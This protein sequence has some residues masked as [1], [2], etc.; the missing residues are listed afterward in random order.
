MTFLLAL[1]FASV[2]V[3][4]APVPSPK[5]APPKPAPPPVFAGTVLGPDAKPV[6]DAVVVAMAAGEFNDPPIVTR[7]A[8]DGTFRVTARRRG[9]HTI[10][11]EARGLAAQTIERAATPLRVTLARGGTIEGT[12]RDASTGAPVAG[13]RVEARED[14]ARAP[15]SWDPALG[16]V[17]TQTDAGGAFR[18]D[19]LA[20][21]R[22]TVTASSRAAGRASQSGVAL[23]Q[24]VALLTVAGASIAGR[25]LAP[26]GK[27]VAGA[28]VRA[29]ADIGREA[30]SDPSGRFEIDGL[31][32]GSY[33]LIA[34][35][36]DWA[37]T[38]VSGIRVERMGETA[39]DV[40]LA[41]PSRVT[42]RLVDAN[43][44]AVAGT[45][46]LQEIDG[47][48]VPRALG[49][50]MRAEAG[51]D[52]RFVL[53]HVPPGS[54][55]LAVN[56]RGMTARRVPIDVGGRQAA[57]DLGDVV[58]EA[59]PQIKGRVRDK[60]GAPVADATLRAMPEGP[61][62]PGA[63]MP[64]EG[65]TDADGRFV[66]GG[67]TSAAYRLIVQAPA[68]APYLQS[69]DA[70]G[71][72]DIVL[73]AAGS[74]AGSVVDGAG[75]PVEAFEVTAQPA[76]AREGAMRL[77][78]RDRAVIDEG[79][80][81]TLDGVNAG[82]YVVTIS[83]ADLG[84]GVVSDV[85]VGSGALTD[86][87]RVRLSP[88]GTIRGTVV[89]S[90]GAAV[91]AAT[92]EARGPEGMFTV[93][94][95]FRETST[96]AAGA[97]QLRG[98]AP[99]RLVV[100]AHHPDYA[101]GRS[102]PVDVDAARPAETTIVMSRGGRVEGVVRRRGA[103]PAAEVVIN[104]RSL[105]E[106][107]SFAMSPGVLPGPDGAFVVDRVPPGRVGVS[108]MA[109]QRTAGGT[110]GTFKEAV[111]REGE[112][113]R[114]DFLLRDILVSGKVT[115]GGAPLANVRLIARSMGSGTMY[116]MAG[117][118]P[119][120]AS[121]PQR[122]MAVTREDGSYEMI[123]GD[124]GQVTIRAQAVAGRQAYPIRMVEI[125]DA[126]TQT[127]DLDFP[128]GGISGIVVDEQTDAPIA[129]ASVFSQPAK[130]G[131]P[132]GGMA[133][134][135]ADGRFAIDADAGEF[136]VRARAEGYAADSVTVTVS[137]SPASDVRIRL[138]RGAPL[139][140]K[141]LDARGRPAAGVA[142]LARPDDEVGGTVSADSSADGMFEF[143]ALKPGT[144]TLAAGSGLAGFGMLSGVAP[145]TE[146]VLLR[147]S[148]GGR[149]RV[150]AKT[151]AGVPV[152]RAYVSVRSVNGQRLE[153]FNGGE[154]TAADGTAT[155]DVPAGMIELEAQTLKGSGRG[156]A[157]VAVGGLG[158]VHITI[159]ETPATAP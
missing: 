154:S 33:R 138:S 77:G 6:A 12:V 71:E 24:R 102:A 66:L 65:R 123:V 137:D 139:R 41:P 70:P 104:V 145:G 92:V 39:A 131:G 79:G 56:G 35:H 126:D 22:H 84:R 118:I 156:Q 38:V 14:G 26:D 31:V 59:G 15:S 46:A 142:V 34:R 112:T 37:V 2:V 61:R 69:V 7:T 57:V 95:D 80:R 81:F 64:L 47:L 50:L 20:R 29:E 120:P 25:V 155:L 83:A 111:V 3:A 13:A 150:T 105:E 113:T 101:D 60:A 122:M 67:A 78:P 129:R 5:A 17:T 62:V 91:V 48:P 117:A 43:E 1:V 23:G 100:M 76:G 30:A 135:A 85:K 158:A 132:G 88:G 86:V 87:G 140:G 63:S 40:I 49:I 148:P 10:R 98:V 107:A 52:G 9:A 89:D 141:V 82:T 128:A 147:L 54:H 116:G 108:L 55:A 127:V 106:P 114:V 73:E 32:S 152:E 124:P 115:R 103:G 109:S 153:M 68:F 72:V 90:S 97:F 94:D 42:G 159:T 146:G 36:K 134:S 19:G 110:P 45:I 27:P 136:V 21:G 53:D 149:I 16:I 11:V 119:A 143:S 4:P 133:T 18:L 28:T 51:A 93:S 121:G 44:S 96:D 144:Y 8:A 151:P 74:I 99:G 130:P 157:Q 75:R 58:L 125:A